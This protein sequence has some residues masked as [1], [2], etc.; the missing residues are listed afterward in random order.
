MHTKVFFSYKVLLI[1]DLHIIKNKRHSLVH[2]LHNIGLC[3]KQI[4]HS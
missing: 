1:N 3:L 2:N 4:I